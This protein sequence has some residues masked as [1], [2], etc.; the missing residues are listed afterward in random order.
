MRIFA[1]KIARQG[2]SQTP[3]AGAP[4][5]ATQA[6]F[7]LQVSFVPQLAKE[8]G[9]FPNLLQRFPE[10]IPER[11]GKSPAGEKRAI[12]HEAAPVIA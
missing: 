10:E 9:F 7:P 8:G 1:E 5:L 4:Y 11:E 6:A 12:G 3:A 2:V